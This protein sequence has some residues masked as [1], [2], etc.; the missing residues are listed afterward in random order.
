MASALFNYRYYSDEF[1]DGLKSYKYSSVDTSP[2][3][4]YVMKPWWGTFL[5]YFVPMNVSANSMTFWGFMIG[6]SHLI[7][8]TYYDPAV[9]VIQPLMINVSVP[10]WVW[11]Y[12]AVAHFL[13]HT[14]DGSDG[15]QARRTG[16]SSP[17]GELMDH[18]LDSLSV[19][20]IVLSIPSMFAN[21]PP[22]QSPPYEL[23]TLFFVT[24]LGFY[25]SHWEKYLTGVLYLPW[26]YDA[27]MLLAQCL[28]FLQFLT[29]DR[30]LDFVESVTGL[31]TPET[32][33]LSV[34]VS[35]FIFSIPCTLRNIYLASKDKTN[36][37]V[38]KQLHWS[39]AFQPGVPFFMSSAIFIGWHIVGKNNVAVYHTRLFF[40][41]WALIFSNITTRLIVA[42]MCSR[43]YA[44]LNILIL[45]PAIAFGVDVLE[46]ADTEVTMWCLF[47]SL[48]VLHIHYF[49]CLIRQ[50]SS[51]LGVPCL[52]MAK[53]KE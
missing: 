46:L 45:L 43:R 15:M 14:L 2:L 7:L 20:A 44:P 49:A 52:A 18:G 48:L 4:K 51:Y 17:L 32:F 9:T 5:H 53:P 29:N 10:S 38:K 33:L 8:L 37:V 11:L 35:V 6:L 34:I 27:S 22:S 36:P 13:A 3:A 39:T 42:Q 50:F 12:G 23:F 19:S 31:N 28:F 1:M 16:T 25:M 40:Y 47:L 41:S 30:V 26:T 24:V 21:H